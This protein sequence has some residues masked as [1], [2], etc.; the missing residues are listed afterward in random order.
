[1]AYGGRLHSFDLESG[2]GTTVPVT[3]D[4]KQCLTPI[5]RHAFS[6]EDDHIHLKNIRGATIRADGKQ[7]AFSVLRKLYTMTLPDG[8][9]RRVDG[10]DGQFQPAYSPDGNWIAFA[11]WGPDGGH[12]WKVPSKGGEAIQLTKAA[13][14]YQTP[15]WSPDG[16]SIAFVG[17]PDVTLT[18]PG[19]TTLVAGGNIQI[20]SIADGRIEKLPALARAGHPLAFTADGRRIHYVEFTEDYD[21]GLR[22]SAVGLDGVSRRHH[23][24]STLLP[25][26]G[27][28]VA[29]PSPDGRKLALIKSGNLYLAQCEIPIGSSRFSAKECSSRQITNTGAYD[30]RWAR[31]GSYLEWSFANR[32]YK[33][34][35][36]SLAGLDG[37]TMP[38]IAGADAIQISMD[39]PR[40]R[41]AGKIMFLGARII[42]LRGKEIIEDGAILVENGRITRVG[43]S[44]DVS[45][46]TDAIVISVHGKTILPGFIDSHAHLN[47]LP[48][49]L[50]DSN[51]GEA[52][53]YL[54]FGVTTVKNPSNGGDHA[55][56]Y[57]ELIE[58][59]DM[60][61]PRM[62]GAEGL[63]EQ[64]QT[65]E[66][67]ED[68]RNLALRT[69]LL[70]GKFLKYHTGWDR[71]GRRW[72]IDA[73]GEAGLN[74]AA[75][76]PVSNYIPGRINFTTIADGV[77]SSEHEFSDDQQFQ[78]VSKYLA[79]SGTFINF[80]PLGGYGR[81]GGRYWPQIKNDPRI[82]R[83]HVGRIPRASVDRLPVDSENALPPLASPADK[84]A[85]LI[86]QI[87]HEGGNVTIGSHGDFD[88][89][90]FHW[91]M[92]A[93]VRG[94]MSSHEVL[95]AATLNGARSLGMEEYL[96]SIERGKIAD[97]LILDKN[98][99]DD[100]RNTLSVERVMKDG[101][102]R[103]AMTLDEVWPIPAPMP[104]WRRSEG[105]NGHAH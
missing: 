1:V 65:I 78:D 79:Q 93:H 100:I 3:I 20:L 96:G 62:F 61:G 37:G 50:L 91:E 33:L 44:S 53:A 24:L 13:G 95:E 56:A 7:L 42:T 51:N 17:H 11:T 99:I 28:A 46:P 75:H 104:H 23:E 57:A 29:L 89:I 85:R 55:H 60:I 14:Y 35:I 43:F 77:T 68:A 5:V 105:S 54:A 67:F 16:K 97:L 82:Q 69:K 8:I 26:G 70:G 59:G 21:V 66:S 15:T 40:K 36:D 103:D 80:A 39:V 34:R 88:G 41:A 25:S 72:I 81:Y 83:F 6:L 63:V 10:H 101:V 71:R 9:P 45:V 19:F 58:S 38:A 102:L 4:V 87:A 49:D 52:L 76:F 48:R 18:R 27:A 84:N 92:W 22:T 32:H 86:A 2:T 98:P 94:G 73:A 74:V 30:P 31:D 47:D 90:G 64:S 12:L